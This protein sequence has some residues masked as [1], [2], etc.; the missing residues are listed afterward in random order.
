MA[1]VRRRSDPYQTSIGRSSAGTVSASSVPDCAD[2]SS[3]N[4]EIRAAFTACATASSITAVWHSH[5]R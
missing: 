5:R 2:V 4:T 1:A 3:V